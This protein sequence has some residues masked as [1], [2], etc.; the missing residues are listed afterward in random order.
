MAEAE[1]RV[2]ELNGNRILGIVVNCLDRWMAYALPLHGVRAAQ[3]S[4]VYS[5]SNPFCVALQTPE[6]VFHPPRCAH[7]ERRRSAEVKDE[8]HSKSAARQL[9][10]MPCSDAITVR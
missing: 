8:Q 2:A 6:A 3:R 10:R 4:M 1:Q 9:E 5:F 7:P